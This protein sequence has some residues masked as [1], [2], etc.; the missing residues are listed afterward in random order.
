MFQ[1]DAQNNS[2]VNSTSQIFM[3]DVNSASTINPNNMA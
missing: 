2:Q 3:Q 1:F